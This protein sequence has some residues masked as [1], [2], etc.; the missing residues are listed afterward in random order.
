M[1]PGFAGTEAIVKV[2]NALVPQLL[3]PETVSGPVVNN[4]EK[5][6][7]TELVPCPLAIDALAGA[8]QL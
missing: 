5:F 7:D 3:V 1:V 2:R 4:A 8:V 6:T